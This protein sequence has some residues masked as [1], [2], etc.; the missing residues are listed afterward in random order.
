VVALR[1]KGH[2]TGADA[3]PGFTDIS[4]IGTGSLATVY[5]A[6]EISTNRQVALKLLNVRD[7]SPRALESFQRESMALGALSAHPNIV[8]LFRT[9]P[10]PD[11]RPVLVLELCNGAV[12][13]RLRAGA[14]LP[15]QEAVSIA[16]KVAGA[17]E[18]AHRAAILHRDVKPQNILVTEFGEPALADFGVA[19]LQS[20][21]QTTA[22]LFDFTTLHAAPELLEG[23]ETSAA[24]DVYELASTLY[25]LIVG[26]SAFRSYDGESPA[27]V[28]LRILRDPVQPVLQAGVPVA[29]SDLLVWAMSK[30]K[31]HRPPTAAEFAVELS[32]IE[33]QQGWPRTQ[34]LIRDESVGMAG[35]SPTITRLPDRPLIESR[36]PVVAMPTNRLPP[37]PLP[38]PPLPPPPPPT[39]LPAPSAPPRAAAD[40]FSAPRL[41]FAADSQRGPATPQPPRPPVVEPEAPA[42]PAR[43]LRPAA[44]AEEDIAPVPDVSVPV[45]PTQPDEP[46][47]PDEPAAE[48]TEADEQSAAAADLAESLDPDVPDASPESDEPNEPV[49]LPDLLAALKERLAAL[50]AADPPERAGEPAPPPLTRPA[51]AEAPP[52][53]PAPVPSTPYPLRPERTPLPVSA[54]GLATAPPTTPPAPAWPGP[55]WTDVVPAPPPTPTP[56]ESEPP[57]PVRYP[58]PPAAHA[59]TPDDNGGFAQ[60]A[61]A[62]RMPRPTA[63]TP[64]SVSDLAIDPMSLRRRLRLHAGLT[65]LTV[66]E[67]RLTLRTRIKRTRIPWT[68]VLGFEPNYEPAGS[69]GITS[70]S[71]VALTTV[72]PVPLPATH[73]SVAEVRYAQAMLDAYRVRAQLAQ[74]N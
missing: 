62:L 57:E 49:P 19:M 37:G 18:T 14:Q 65:A 70:G 20:S 32:Q 69:E 16:V 30:D 61:S 1:R 60:P 52:P 34:F 24:T 27:S 9:F 74:N 47:E 66:D 58:I 13:D 48:R 53:T 71:V 4:E 36:P 6:R 17:L 51:P 64:Q 55:Q 72:G 40:D 8:T 50:E 46:D 38:P 31:D 41:F 33:V 23:G 56:A 26:Q 25:Q 39:P 43:H 2:A 44:E 59:S 21:T 11:G 12:S 22:G 28:I 3:F 7:A 15:V 29:L 45:T 5:R 10:V 42:Q 35:G 68:D 54:P 67:R 73:G 63:W